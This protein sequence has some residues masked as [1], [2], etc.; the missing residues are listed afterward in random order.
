M[1]VHYA[2]KKKHKSGGRSPLRDH[3]LY[4]QAPQNVGVS[5]DSVG[6]ED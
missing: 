5:D 3:I 4:H 6:E 2:K 1:V